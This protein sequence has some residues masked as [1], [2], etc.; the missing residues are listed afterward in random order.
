MLSIDLGTTSCLARVDHAYV[1]VQFCAS[2]EYMTSA[3]ADNLVQLLLQAWGGKP[4]KKQEAQDI[5]SSLANSE[6]QLGKHTEPLPGW[7][8]LAGS[9]SRRP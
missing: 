1:F 6:A 4:D 9:Q 2:A 5:L 8:N 7:P 3:N